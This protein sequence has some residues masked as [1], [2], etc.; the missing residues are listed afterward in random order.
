[1][2]SGDLGSSLGGAALVLSCG[3]GGVACGLP[4]WL[5]PGPLV[6]ASGIALFYD[7]GCDLLQVSTAQSCIRHVAKLCGCFAEGIAL[8]RDCFW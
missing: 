5:M 2:L 6:A 8:A 3:A 1:M 4:I 7:S